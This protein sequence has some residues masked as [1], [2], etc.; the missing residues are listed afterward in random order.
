MKLILS[1]HGNTFSPAEKAVWVGRRSDLA[2]VDEGQRQAKRL[3]EKLLEAGILPTAV[4]CGPLLRTRNYAE[5]VIRTLG[6]ALQPIVADSL[7]EIDYG[8]WEGL[9]NREIEDRYGHG[10]LEAWENHGLWPVAAGWLPAE[11]QLA[12]RV[13]AFAS[14]LVR[15]HAASDT[16]LA[17]TSNG[18]LRYFLRLDPVSFSARAEMRATK[19]ATGHVCIMVLSE[20]RH[21]VTSWNNAPEA[22]LFSATPDSLESGRAIRNPLKVRASFLRDGLSGATTQCSLGSLLR[23]HAA[24]SSHASRRKR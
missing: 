14:S 8:H 7:T 21:R 9:S 16:V 11:A 24:A 1:R 22:Q 4:Y 2:L 12:Q 5:I 20:A 3:G 10:P 6:I 18:V 13:N 17:I 15:T 19:V 23:A